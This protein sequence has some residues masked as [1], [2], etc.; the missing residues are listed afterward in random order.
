MT[1]IHETYRES[2]LMPIERP[3]NWYLRKHGGNEIFGPVHFDKIR[4]WAQSAQVAPQDVVSEN[5]EVWTKAPMIPELEMDWLVQLTDESFY[6]PTTKGALSEFLVLGEISADTTII[7]CCSGRIL[8]YKDADF[9]PK[10]AWESGEEDIS[11]PAKRSI[12]HNLQ[13]RIRELELALVE[14]HR[15]LRM[16]E[17]RIQKLESRVKEL[18]PGSKAGN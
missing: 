10:S 7:D 3:D 18:T 16:A 14:K 9:Y 6:G 4:E 15:L 5:G 13:Q 17:D 11:Q 2:L 1:A 8:S 12:R